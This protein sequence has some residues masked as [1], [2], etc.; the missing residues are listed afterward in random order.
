MLPS[1]TASAAARLALKGTG[2]AT[3]DEVA[4]AIEGGVAAELAFA[5]MAAL[6]SRFEQ[7]ADEDQLTIVEL[8][9]AAPS[10]AMA[11]AN[12]VMAQD[13]PSTL[14]KQELS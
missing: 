11:A 2:F 6:G 14:T 13:G 9:T 5:V 12:A 7:L 4:A 1:D 10:A 3:S 8:Y